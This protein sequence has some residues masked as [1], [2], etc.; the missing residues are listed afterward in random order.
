[1]SHDTG[2]SEVHD[3]SNVYQLYRCT[4]LLAGGHQSTFEAFRT[5]VRRLIAPDER[6]ATEGPPM[7]GR[8]ARCRSSCPA[9]PRLLRL[10][11]CYRRDGKITSSH[12]SCCIE[13]A[14]TRMWRR[15]MKRRGA[16]GNN[17]APGGRGN[18]ARQKH[19]HTGT[20]YSRC[21]RRDGPC[22]HPSKLASAAHGAHGRYRPGAPLNTF[23]TV[24]TPKPLAAK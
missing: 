6:G 24:S 5:S 11:L 21:H 4:C 19:T 16:V 13:D 22:L 18:S 23:S 7:P 17:T 2:R 14:W 15:H 20:R 10:A 1:M 9:A 3:D 12:C 8:C